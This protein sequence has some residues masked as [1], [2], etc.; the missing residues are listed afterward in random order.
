ML[1]YTH[2]TRSERIKLGELKKKGKV[3]GKLPENLVVLYP[4]SAESFA[5]T[6]TRTEAT[7]TGVQRF[8]ISFAARNVIQPPDRK[9]EPKSAVMWKTAFLIAGLLKQLQHAGIKN[10]L[11][12][13]CRI[14]RF[15]VGLQPEN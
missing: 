3:S 7:I 1:S 9:K 4:V 6:E 13:I 11:K 14:Q 5:E 8:F 2:F 12:T 10:I 15:I